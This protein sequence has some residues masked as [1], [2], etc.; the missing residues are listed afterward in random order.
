MPKSL[1]PPSGVSSAFDADT[2]DGYS[3]DGGGDKSVHGNPEASKTRFPTPSPA[4]EKVCG[5]GPSIAEHSK[6]AKAIK[7]GRKSAAYKKN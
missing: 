5:A 2:A 1:K 7:G 4:T 3:R 6:D